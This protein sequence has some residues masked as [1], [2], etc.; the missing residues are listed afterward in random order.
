MSEA[1]EITKKAKSNLAFAF[2]FLPKDRRE[3]MVTFY[4][5]CRVIDD[6]ADD[7]DISYENKRS[8]LDSW[9]ACFQPNAQSNDP[10]QNEVLSIRDRYQIDNQ[11]FLDLIEGCESDLE[12]SRRFADWA[13]LEQYTYRVACCVGLISIEIFGCKDPSSQKYA[14]ALGHALQLTN[15]IRDVGEDLDD[16]L[17]VYLPLEDMA[18]FGYSEELL[19]QRVYDQ[20]FIEL[21]NYLADRAEGYY[22]EAVAALPQSDKK[23]LSSAEGMRCIYHAILWKIRDSQFDVFGQRHSISKMRK[24]WYIIRCYFS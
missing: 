18:K 10:L 14:I 7:P 23:A 17:R 19:R 15:I 3:D 24:L 13:E 5:F 22:A 11:L 21:M 16:N 9:I 4:A 6:L 2:L 1:A 20:R 8:G 12:P